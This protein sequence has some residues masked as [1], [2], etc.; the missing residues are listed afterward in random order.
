MSNQLKTIRLLKNC[1]TC[2]SKKAKTLVKRARVR[3]RENRLLQ[4]FLQFISLSSLSPPSP[5]SLKND[6]SLS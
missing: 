6:T 3:T 5:H 2:D 1:D 4:V